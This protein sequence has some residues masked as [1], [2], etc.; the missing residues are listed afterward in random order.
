MFSE[1]T[2]GI[3]II[4]LTILAVMGFVRLVVWLGDFRYECRDTMWNGKGASLMKL[5]FFVP[6][7]C[8]EILMLGFDCLTAWSWARNAKHAKEWFDR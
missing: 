1:G 3:F 5:L 8:L 6:Y 7:L 4:I 2:I